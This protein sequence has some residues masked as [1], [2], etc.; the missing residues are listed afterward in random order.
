MGSDRVLI[1]IAAFAFAFLGWEVF[2]KE[3]PEELRGGMSERFCEDQYWLEQSLRFKRPPAWLKSESPQSRDF[4]VEM[5]QTCF[6]DRPYFFPVGQR[7]YA[8][9]DGQLKVVTE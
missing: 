7:F 5:A 9:E 1:A 8:F 4:H 3:R 6:P 2:L